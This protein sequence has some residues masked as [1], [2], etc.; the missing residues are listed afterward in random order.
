[1]L[2]VVQPFPTP[3]YLDFGFNTVRLQQGGQTIAGDNS[4]AAASP[5]DG[6]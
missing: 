5:R 2:A 6:R 4:R 1:M 3:T